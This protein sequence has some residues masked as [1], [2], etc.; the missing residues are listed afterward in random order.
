MSSCC[1]VDVRSYPSGPLLWGLTRQ[2]WVDDRRTA[3]LL[4]QWVSS[5]IPEGDITVRADPGSTPCPTTAVRIP[6]IFTAVTFSVWKN[7][8][9]VATWN[10]LFFFS[11]FSEQLCQI[12]W[13]FE[14]QTQVLEP[15]EKALQQNS[16]LQGF[17][18]LNCWNLAFL[19]DCGEDKEAAVKVIRTRRQQ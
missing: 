16:P 4:W 19:Q 15:A 13:V 2:M 17:R 8:S 9:P 5:I 10:K 18:P 14:Y 11:F 12:C 1:H 6:H 3:D 7:F